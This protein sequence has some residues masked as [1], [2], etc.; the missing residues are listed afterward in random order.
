MA[1]RKVASLSFRAS[2]RHVHI[3][4]SPGGSMAGCQAERRATV[5]PYDPA[6]PTHVAAS[7]GNRLSRET[8]GDESFAAMR[9]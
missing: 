8:C 6:N 7:F 3:A 9:T 2:P 4:P 5:P 1:A